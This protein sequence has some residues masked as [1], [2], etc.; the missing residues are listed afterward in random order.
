ML[1][2]FKEFINRGNVVDLA[3]AVVIGAAFTAVTASFTNDVLMQLLAAVGGEPDFS[4]LTFTL[5][6]AVIRYGAFLTAVI[7]F[8]I[9]AF[10][11]FLVVKAINR[12]QNLRAKEE[13]AEEEATVT[14]AD[15]LTE[16]RDLLR[17]QA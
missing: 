7:N 10:S 9:V 14:E 12:V 13:A 2:E 16:I 5:N 15:L 11:M 4:S 6:D 1:Q 8:V 3:V 17:A